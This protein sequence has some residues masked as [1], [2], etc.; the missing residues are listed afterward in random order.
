M[1]LGFPFGFPLTPPQNKRQLHLDDLLIWTKGTSWVE[2]FEGNLSLDTIS[3][4]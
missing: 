1:A 2:F 3:D 4:C